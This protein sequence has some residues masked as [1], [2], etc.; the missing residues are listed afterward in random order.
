ML[1]AVQKVREAAARMQCSNNLKQIGL[2][3][4]LHHDANRSFPT[5]YTVKGS[6]NL[7][8]GGFGG[9]VFLLPYLEQD[10]LYRRW[11][12]NAK[13]Y[14]PPNSTLVSTQV[15]IFDCPR[16]APM[17]SST[18]RFWCRSRDGRCRNL[19]A[20]DYLLCKGANA[21]LREVTQVL[22]PDGASSM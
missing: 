13:W 11:D 4:H 18:C 17:A 15:K 14:D 20:T 5:G 2:A 10:N 16:T 6:D 7:A 12:L 22:R 9:F 3:F 21:A 8:V 1:P 19:A